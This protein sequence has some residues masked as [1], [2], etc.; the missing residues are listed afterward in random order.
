MPKPPYCRPARRLND[1]RPLITLVILLLYG[2]AYGLLARYIGYSAGAVALFP[3]TYIGWAWGPVAGL[4]AGIFV[5]PTHLLLA[6]LAGAS[7]HWSAALLPGLIMSILSGPA[8]GVGGRLYRQLRAQAE[9]LRESEMRLRTIF[10]QLP[11]LLWTT[12]EHLV[13]TSGM[14]ARPST[15]GLMRESQEAVVGKSIYELF[16][17]L[18]PS[19]PPIAVHLGALR[20][21]PGSYQNELNNHLFECHIEPFHGPGGRIVG[22][23]GIALDI[24][25]RHR[26]EEAL[27]RSEERL[28]D[29][30]DHDALTG[31]PNRRRFQEELEH[32]LGS[33][34]TADMYHALL[35]L[36]VDG[37]KYVNDSL[38]H[39]AGDD[40]LKSLAALLRQELPN[41]PDD[42]VARLGGD[43][44][45]MILP[46]RSQ[47]DAC[48]IAERIVQATRKNITIVRGQPIVATVS[49]GIAV[50]PLHGE[51]GESLLAHADLAMYQSKESGR[52]GFSV[53]D[54]E[55]GR[56]T[57]GE[58]KLAWEA[59]IRLA[60]DENRFILHAQPIQT[61]A[62][63]GV[64][65]YELLLR[66]VGEDGALILPG[67]FLDVAEKFGQI[68]EIDRWVVT[69]AI[70][71]SAGL[72]ELGEMPRLAVNLSGKAFTDPGLL[73]LILW[74]LER[75][76][77]NPAQLVMEI[78]ETALITDMAQAG[79]WI[80][81]LRKVGCKFAIDDFG[82]GFSSFSHLRRLPLDYLKID[83][84]YV[85]NLPYDESNQHLIRSMVEIA[86][87]LG[88]STIAEFVGD[89]PTVRLIR[90]CGVDYGQ[91][92]YLGKPAP[93][94]TWW[95]G[96]GRA[97]ANISTREAQSSL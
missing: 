34:E 30:A 35:F 45:A 2:P 54:P 16:V 18:D 62:G 31:L 49:I 61:L 14:G 41:A 59:R 96:I 79:D 28:R 86:R 93:L 84:S 39:Q 9:S 58:Q 92:F 26:S 12:D 8:A 52:N 81:T 24:S 94:E 13:I 77:V 89:E 51:T 29:L 95:P 67:A 11:A 66:M 4:V 68:R 50:Y 32:R 10:N 36:D 17:T 7:Y 76:Q 85:R 46:G 78:T 69:H 91:G 19:F 73:P 44:F 1:S 74:E 63:G 72:R 21:I 27:R 97:V 56:R 48:V 80:Q 25:Q 55:R 3:L 75:T 40:L 82:S 42:F 57:E 60:L 5:F 90:E 83:G 43:E 20:G 87:G 71:L 33:S 70:R 22:T 65:H 6:S 38:G 88:M 47:A 53:Y 15:D 23:I 37:F 64:V